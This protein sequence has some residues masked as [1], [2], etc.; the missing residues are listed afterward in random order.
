[1]NTGQISKGILYLFLLAGL[2]LTWQC[3]DGNS[4]NTWGVPFPKIGT[5]SSPRLVDLTGDGVL[6]VVI[7]AGRNEGIPCDEG[8]IALDGVDGAILWTVH[9]TDQIVGSPVFLDVSEDGIPDIFI[10]GRSANFVAISGCDGEIIWRYHPITGEEGVT[11]N[12]RFNFYT[13]QII[14]DQDGDNV[15][16]ILVTNGGNVQAAPGNEMHRYPGVLLILSSKTGKILAADTM[17][18]G[19][20][21]YMSPLL[22]NF[23]RSAGMEIVFGTGGETIGGSLYRVPLS[24]LVSGDIGGAQRLIYGSTHGFIAPPTLVDIT[25]DGVLDIVANYHAGIMYAIDGWSDSILWKVEMEDC[26]ANSTPSPGYFND[27]DVP[28]LF[29]HFSVGTWPRNR[30]TRQVMVDGRNG[31]I[32]LL[33]SLGCTG[34]FSPV[35]FDFDQDG[36]DETLL[37]V[38]D[39]NCL[40]IH[41]TDILHRMMV[42]DLEEN[43]RLQF[44]ETSKMKN[45]SSTPWLGDMDNDGKLDLVFTLQTNTSVILEFHGMALFR[46][47]TSIDISGEPAWGAYLGSQYD[48]IFLR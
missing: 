32:L 45:V 41:V 1:M 10:G 12:A 30:G 36:Q 31:E 3:R 35:V 20:E 34:F 22:A 16:D 9:S 28:D 29:G 48:G 15:E 24:A 44:G 47:A 5:N 21:T 2:I 40:G 13:P 4:A 37:P 43:Q 27:D 7:G 6:D 19:K 46:S 33:D 23:G 25:K 26:E 14:P 17:P 38:N 18:D 42:F 11:A 39:F 8:V